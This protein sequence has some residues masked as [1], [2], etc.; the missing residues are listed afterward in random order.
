MNT[1]NTVFRNKSATYIGGYSVP[2]YVLQNSVTHKGADGDSAH[3]NND[4]FRTDLN[5]I[6]A[7]RHELMSRQVAVGYKSTSSRP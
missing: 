4:L 2:V 6:P 5:A 3:Y 7:R 1:L